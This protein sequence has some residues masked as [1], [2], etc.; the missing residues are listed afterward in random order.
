[1]ELIGCTTDKKRM[2]VSLSWEEVQ[3][4]LNACVEDS[5]KLDRMGHRR[6]DAE[7]IDQAAFV[8]GVGNALDEAWVSGWH[9]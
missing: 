7:M 2:I 8:L 9:Q 5:S 4:L 1:V 3:A 6:N